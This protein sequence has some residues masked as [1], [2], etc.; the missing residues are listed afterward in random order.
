MAV[1]AE[2]TLQRHYGRSFCR[3]NLNSFSLFF[4][5]QNTISYRNLLNQPD[6]ECLHWRV[7]AVKTPSIRLILTLA[8]ESYNL[9]NN[10][11][12]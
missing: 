9:V 10:F 5:N 6:T 11:A 7:A 2:Y 3:I 12:N 4:Q 8:K 1:Y